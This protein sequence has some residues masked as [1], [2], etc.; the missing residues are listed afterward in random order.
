MADGFEVGKTYTYNAGKDNASHWVV[1][2]DGGDTVCIRQIGG[3]H[4]HGA[5][6]KRFFKDKWTLSYPP[7]EPFE[8]Y[9]SLS[10]QPHCEG[11]GCINLGEFPVRSFGKG[12]SLKL[13]EQCYLNRERSVAMVQLGQDRKR[14][15]EIGPVKTA[16][17][18]PSRW[19][20]RRYIDTVHEIQLRGKR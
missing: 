3:W 4:F 13:C 11:V 12:L 1:Q 9:A 10:K 16:D 7:P 20:T 5:Y 19:P 6:P 2:G 18:L 14:M 8:E 15:A 17:D